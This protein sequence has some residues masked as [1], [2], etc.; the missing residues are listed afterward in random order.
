M[1][2]FSAQLLAGDLEPPD[3]AATSAQLHAWF[4]PDSG[5][6]TRVAALDGAILGYCTVS[7]SQLVHLFVDPARQGTGLGRRLLAVAEALM[8]ASGHP[9]FQLHTRV[10][11][12]NAV[13]FYE[14]AGW[15]V[16]GRTVRTVEHG[17]SYEERVLIK[18][19]QPA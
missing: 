5:F 19:H 4:L 17:L 12:L 10:E 18:L 7:G 1:K 13:G 9:T 3:R 11:N 2:T 14:N 8:A 15:T 16:T 6:D